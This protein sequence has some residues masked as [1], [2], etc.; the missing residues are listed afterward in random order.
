M[1]DDVQKSIVILGMRD[2]PAAHAGL[3][4]ASRRDWRATAGK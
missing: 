1:S 4:P 2:R 3:R